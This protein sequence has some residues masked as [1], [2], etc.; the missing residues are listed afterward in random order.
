MQ[1]S[2][3]NNPLWYNHFHPNW[4]INGRSRA[5]GVV[6]RSMLGLNDDVTCFGPVSLER[7]HPLGADKRGGLCLVL[8][9]LIYHF[10]WSQRS[11]S[12]FMGMAYN[13]AFFTSTCWWNQVCAVSLSIW[14]LRLYGRRLKDLGC[15]GKETL[16]V[17]HMKSLRGGVMCR[18]KDEGRQKTEGERGKH[19]WPWTTKPVIRVIFF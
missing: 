18:R 15:A 13:P 14:V 10:R 9:T 3:Q 6:D 8:Q 16:F 17:F 5:G 2:M 11:F 19:M 1:L 7:E 12:G 4:W